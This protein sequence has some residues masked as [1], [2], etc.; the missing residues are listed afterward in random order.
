MEN[1]KLI[2]SDR[3]I[4]YNGAIA[5]VAAVFAYSLIVMIYAII[6]SSVT[7]CSIMPNGERNTILLANG[8][9]VAYSVAIFSLLMAAISAVAGSIAAVILKKSLQYF[10]VQFNFKKAI[11]I[12]C[13]TAIAM[14]TLMYILFR[15]L[16]KDWMTFKYAETFIFWFLVPAVIFLAACIIGGSYLNNVLDKR[17]K[18]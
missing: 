4:A 16:L 7:I 18:Q 17:L 8:F 12:S 11:I 2:I 1:S 5:A 15:A 9:S 13:V 3:T 10:N 14:L 6:R